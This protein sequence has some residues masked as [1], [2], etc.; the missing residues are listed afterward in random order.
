M[1]LIVTCDL[2][3]ICIHES[4]VVARASC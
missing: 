1:L 3:I 2:V 4:Q